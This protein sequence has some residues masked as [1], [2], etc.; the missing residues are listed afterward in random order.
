[1]KLNGINNLRIHTFTI[2]TNKTEILNDLTINKI[3]FQI[4]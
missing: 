1:M 3:L 2:I 4:K